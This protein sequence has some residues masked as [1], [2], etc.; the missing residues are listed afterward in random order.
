M[1]DFYS[2]T[3]EVLDS[4]NSQSYFPNICAET[5]VLVNLGRWPAFNAGSAMSSDM[6]D[7]GDKIKTPFDNLLI[8][9]EYLETS[10]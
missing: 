2:E 10:Q 9:K 8:A 1:D 7:L 6:P 3:K 4:L 5:L